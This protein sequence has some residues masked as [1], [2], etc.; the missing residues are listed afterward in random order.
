MKKIKINFRYKKTKEP[1]LLHYHLFVDETGTVISWQEDENE[2]GD[3]EEWY[4]EEK[5]VE[6]YVVINGE[7]YLIGGEE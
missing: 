3:L 7:E 4:T 5:Q 6:A 1:H 2:E